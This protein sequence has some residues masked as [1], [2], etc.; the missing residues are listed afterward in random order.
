MILVENYDTA[1]DTIWNHIKNNNQPVVV[2]TDMNKLDYYNWKYKYPEWN[3][4]RNLHYQVVYG[5]YEQ[6]GERYFRIYDPWTANRTKNV[7]SKYQYQD[8]I[9][10]SQATPAWVYQYGSI[11]NNKYNPAYIMLVYGN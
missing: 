5:I 10:M 9:A 2:I 1:I 4:A 8:I 7:F 6:N 11:E 3:D